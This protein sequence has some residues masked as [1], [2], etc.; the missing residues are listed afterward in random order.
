MYLF[1]DYRLEI[2]LLSRHDQILL[3]AAINLHCQRVPRIPVK[4]DK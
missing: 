4:L 2:S 3:R 1:E